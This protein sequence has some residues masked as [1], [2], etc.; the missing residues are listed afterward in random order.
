MH[1]QLG[2]LGVVVH[3]FKLIIF[4]KFLDANLSAAT[5]TVVSVNT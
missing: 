4:M 1:N 5:S 2:A 3:P